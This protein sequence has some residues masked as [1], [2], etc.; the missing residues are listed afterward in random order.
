MTKEIIVNKEEIK[1]VV[2]EHNLRILKKNNVPKGAENV[3]EEK[4]ERHE[5]IMSREV[6]D[7]WELSWSSYMEVVKKIERKGKRLLATD[8]VRIQLQVCNI[9]LSEEDSEGR[10]DSK[11]VPRNEA[12]N[13]LEEEGITA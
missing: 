3:V 8:K 6:T 5:E 11:E 12:D 9:L 1:N 4:K 2:L 13:D 7:D 10:K